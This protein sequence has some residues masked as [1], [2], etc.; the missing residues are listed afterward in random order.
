MKTI[1]EAIEQGDAK[2]A[3]NVRNLMFTFEDFLTVSEPG[4]RELLGQLDKKTLAVSERRVGGERKHVFYSDV[5]PCGRHAEG[6]HGGAWAGAVHGRR[7]A[8]Q[9]AV[10]VARQLEL[11]GKMALKAETTEDV[12]LA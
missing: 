3:A 9:E 2:L 8:Q 4:I 11:E 10:S 1:L 6:R 7:K 5:D 12:Y